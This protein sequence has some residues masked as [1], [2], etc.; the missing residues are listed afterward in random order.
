MDTD[1]I[2]VQVL[3]GRLKELQFELCK[4]LEHIGWLLYLLE[5]RASHNG[6]LVLSSWLG[7]TLRIGRLHRNLGEHWFREHSFVVRCFGDL[8]TCFLGRF[9]SDVRQ[10]A[11]QSSSLF[12]RCTL[13][14]SIYVGSCGRSHHR[15]GARLVVRAD[16]VS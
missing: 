14:L 11:A 15:R 8:F 6:V 2:V 16:S 13:P 3:E 4:F 9:T 1:C 10:L 12:S 7:L 5:I